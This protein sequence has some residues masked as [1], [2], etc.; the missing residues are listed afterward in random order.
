MYELK[1]MVRIVDDLIPEVCAVTDLD[2]RSPRFGSTVTRKAQCAEFDA[3]GL[4]MLGFAYAH[5]LSRYHADDRVFT[6]LAAQCEYAHRD[7]SPEGLTSL[8][9]T[10]WHSPPDTAFAVDTLVP[11]LMSCRRHLDAPCA[12]AIDKLL[13]PLVQTMARG[14]IG[15][16]FHT[17]NHRWVIT[18]ALSMAGQLFPD[19]DADA[20]VDQLLGEGVDIDAD[21]QYSE[22]STGIYNAVSNRGLIN[23]AIYRDRPDLFEPVRANLGMMADMFHHDASVVTLFSARQD[24]G[25]RVVPMSLAVSYLLMGLRDGN[26]EW[27]AYADQLFA[28]STHDRTSAL[29][30][31]PF[32]IDPEAAERPP[33]HARTKH[34]YT[35][36]F[37]AAGVWR[38]R[39]SELSVTAGV[40]QPQFMSVK[41]GPVEL[42]SVKISLPYFGANFVPHGLEAIDGGI[43]LIDDQCNREFEPSYRLPLGQAVP[44]D[45]LGERHATRDRWPL[46][47]VQMRVEVSRVEDGFD[48]RLRVTGGV[49]GLIGQFECAFVDDG[50]WE[51][52]CGATQAEA[53][54]TALLFAEWGAF[55]REGWAISVGPG[56]CAHQMW[57]MRNSQPEPGFRVVVPFEVAIENHLNIRCGRWSPASRRIVQPLAPAPQAE[58]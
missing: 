12:A 33:I 9:S 42:A 39:D 51:T 38:H 50:V 47:P 7:L 56:S 11:L 55:H 5:P 22:R 13:S 30:L 2:R 28:H 29:L 58:V 31:H 52:P 18:G 36:L 48:L 1:A 17:P 20:Y 10:N 8:K 57:H 53:D 14:I 26:N 6:V 21:G 32:L 4:T 44:L 3:A 41:L 46:P 49:P 34:R 40:G 19:L 25:Q 15:R 23:T 45:R 43:A 54:R 37:P 24:R 16:G 27:L 35:T